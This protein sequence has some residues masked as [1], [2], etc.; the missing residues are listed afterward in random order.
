MKIEEIAHQLPKN[1]KKTVNDLARF[2]SNRTDQNPNFTLLLGA[3]ASVS[4]GIRSAGELIDIW[5]NELC[6]ALGGPTDASPDLSERQKQHLKTKHSD[7]YDPNK[8]YSSLFERRYDLQRQRRMFVESEVANKTPSIGYLYLTHLVGHHFFNTIFTTNFDDLVNEAFYL[9]SDQRPI[10]CAHDSSINSITV[11]SKRPKVIKL[12]GDYL[13]DDIKATTRE[14][15]SL[16]HNTR[17]KFSE[18]AKDYGL[19][20]AGYSG[21]DRSVMDVLMSL[22]KSED[23][24]KGGIYWCIRPGSEV[25]EDLRKLLWKDRVYFVDYSGFDELLAEIYS[26]TFSGDVL[27]L[28]SVTITKKPVHV[29][30]TLLSSL[31]KI[32]SSCSTLV[33]AQKI[34]KAQ[35]QQATLVNLMLDDQYDKR[36]TR[37]RRSQITDEEVIPL[38]ELQ[39][40]LREK[41]FQEV[42]N[43]G[44]LALGVAKLISTKKRILSFLIQASQGLK[45]KERALDF[46]E[47]RIQLGQFE[48]RNYLLKAELLETPEQKLAEVSKA[49]KQDPS[50]APSYHEIAD[51]LEDQSAAV[52]GIEKDKLISEALQMLDTGIRVG[53]HYSNYC[54]RKKF[55]LIFSYRRPKAERTKQLKQIISDIETQ[56]PYCARVLGMRAAL[57]D[58][59]TAAGEVDKLLADIDEAQKRSDPDSPEAFIHVRLTALSTSCRDKELGRFIDGIEADII[60]G[61]ISLARKVA[62][63]LRIRL[64]ENERAISIL[65]AS[66]DTDFEEESASLL[67]TALVEA[68]QIEQAKL[69]LQKFDDTFP[70]KQRLELQA[71]VYESEHNYVDAR[72][73]FERLKDIFGNRHIGQIAYYY[74]LQEDYSQAKKL[75]REYLEKFS[76]APDA[77]VEIVNYEFARS[78]LGEKPNENRLRAVLEYDGSPRTKVAVTAIIGSKAELISCI[79][80]AINDDK[81]NRFEFS[82]WPILKDLRTDPDVLKSIVSA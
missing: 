29:V 77:V 74:L 81:T 33:A 23:Y 69:Y 5:R 50:F 17:L 27:P 45:L 44:S 11:T 46:A 54:W 6:H 71:L 21:C 41:K 20:V 65:T 14:T 37:N 62:E 30:N 42:L 48:A 68:D 64:G 60:R 9:F 22:L 72:K 4:S 56:N 43:K 76:F 80:A 32:N 82:R 7:W 19:V 18:F 58:S 3:G 8:E 49:I 63:L 51:I 53:P 47:Q 12:H 13:F 39:G 52:S 75:V 2:I 79:K 10:V 66:L 78:K 28:T 16:E 57:I 61:D 70:I 24:F 38:L 26:A 36:K 15:E 67:V 35:S 31:A 73:C 1:K 40:L 59:D 55:D 34:L 25:S